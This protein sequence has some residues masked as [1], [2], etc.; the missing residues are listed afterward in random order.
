MIRLGHVE[1]FV[2]NPAASR[3]FYESLLGA[4]RIAEQGDFLWIGW[5]GLEIL[6]RP[7]APTAAPNYRASS[8]TLVFYASD[9][10]ALNTSLVE[11]GIAVGHGDEDD[12]L[13]FQDPD[14]H[15]IQAV[16]AP[17]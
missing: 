1:L 15:W 8:Q 13:T 11:K 9:L 16:E 10:A 6:L 14:G 7:G 12:C 17:G 2:H 3:D 5:G 4:D